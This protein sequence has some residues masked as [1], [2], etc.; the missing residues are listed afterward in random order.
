MGEVKV[1][2]NTVQGYDYEAEDS[3]IIV[4]PERIVFTKENTKDYDF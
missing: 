3:G 2:P 4:L 1:E